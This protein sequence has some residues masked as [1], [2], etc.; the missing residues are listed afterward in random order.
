M[1]SS[2]RPRTSRFQALT[3]FRSAVILLALLL[4]PIGGPAWAHGPS[5]DTAGSV[6]A[7]PAGP[8]ETHDGTLLV[9]HEDRDPGSRFRYF[10]HTASEQLELQFADDPPGLLTGDHIRASAGWR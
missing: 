7:Q 3:I 4:A 1:A 9:L 6:S 5:V 10:L 8:L 2:L